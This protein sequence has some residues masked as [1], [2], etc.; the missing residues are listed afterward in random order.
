MGPLHRTH[1]AN[2]GRASRFS[3]DRA[4]IIAFPG[5]PMKIRKANPADV[6]AVITCAHGAYQMY[7]ERIGR[8]PAPMTADFAALIERGIV[9]VG[10]D[11][12]GV[13]CG[14]VVFY[15]RGDSM[16]LE[17]VAVAPG[18]QGHGYGKRLVSF[19]ESEACGLGFASVDLYT[20]EK[21]TEN[22]DLYPRLGYEEIERRQED[23]FNRIY[24]RK[25][26]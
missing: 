24:Y 20:N 12:A 16:H 2:S 25:S 17:N 13:L 7:V 21:M 19:V 4:G 26:L 10:E 9:F 23:G 22:Q 18:K 15:A 3:H 11:A 14:F 1:L 6:T 8:K 5:K